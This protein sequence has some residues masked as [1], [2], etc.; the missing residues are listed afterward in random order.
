MSLNSTRKGLTVY[1]KRTIY[2]LK[3]N[4]ILII[5]SSSHTVR[6]LQ[7]LLNFGKSFLKTI[8]KNTSFNYSVTSVSKQFLLFFKIKI[9]CYNYWLPLTRKYWYFLDK[10]INLM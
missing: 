10:I 2:A 4:V 1:F 5:L 8:C 6:Y 3:L 7:E 9:L